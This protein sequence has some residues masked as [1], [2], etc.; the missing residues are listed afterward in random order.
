L[1][2]LIFVMERKMKTKLFTIILTLLAILSSSFV[3][4]GQANS[5]A[6]IYQEEKTTGAQWYVSTLGSDSN[7]CT[8]LATPCATIQA[9]NIK[10]ADGDTIYVSIGTYY[11]SGIGTEVLRIGKSLSLSGG[12]NETFTLQ[13]GKSIINGEGNR[14]GIVVENAN[15]SVTVDHFII[16]NCDGPTAGGIINWGD[17]TLQN[18]I[19]ENNPKQGID[20]YRDGSITMV[21]SVI[22]NN[23]ASFGAGVQND[24]KLTLVH[25]SIIGNHAFVLGGGVYHTGL[26]LILINSTIKDNKALDGAGIYNDSVGELEIYNSS[27]INNVANENIGGVNGLI[28][29]PVFTQNS[30]IADN[31][32]LMA[33]NAP[34][35][36]GT[37]NSGGYNLIGDNFECAFN[38]TTGD[39]INVEPLAVPIDTY[40]GLLPGSPA[41]DAGNPD[42]CMDDMGNPLLNDQRGSV[43]PLDGNNDGTVVCDIGSFEVDPNRLIQMIYLPLTSKPCPV[44][45]YDDFSNA[46]SGWPKADT[47][48]TLFEY[49]NKEY[50]ILQKTTQNFGAGRPGFE[51]QDY[52]VS[53]DLRNVTGV[54]GSYGIMFGIKQDWSGW[55]TLEVYPDGWYGIYRYGPGGGDVLAE[56]FSPAI[57]QGTASNQ[58]SIERNEYSIIAFANGHLLTNTIDPYLIGSLYLGLINYAYDQSNVDVRYDNFRVDPLYC[59]VN[60][61][62][63]NIVD[64]NRTGW[65]SSPTDF[66]SVNA[67]FAKH[68][69]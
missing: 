54:F 15:S 18:T 8:N 67:N 29:Y 36:Y 26:S 59:P 20:N 63:G 32:V 13:N 48:E 41:I 11:Y 56:A 57:K 5:T 52:K 28:D 21:E 9:A 37:I 6:T 19:I 17:L 12:W 34:D 43:R 51:A 62:T 27:I 2:L 44:L 46:N 49:N 25:S 68:Q 69:P 64:S 4:D 65:Y 22:R 39:L 35:C 3:S 47:S 58:I 66:L 14:P 45:Y 40:Y 61:S 1:V 60:L 31:R 24:G 30:I 23:K 33:G 10:A 55:Y 7:G 16:T 50:R 42:G 38:A 53:V